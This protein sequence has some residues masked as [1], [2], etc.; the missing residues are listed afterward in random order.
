MPQGGNKLNSCDLAA[1]NAWID[2][3]APN[4]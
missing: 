1:I 2:D 4:N 3:G